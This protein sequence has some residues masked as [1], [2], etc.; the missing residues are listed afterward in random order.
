MKVKHTKNGNVKLVMGLEQAQALRAYL[1][2]A[3]RL[4]HEVPLDPHS[5]ELIHNIDDEMS[6][7]DIDPYL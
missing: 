7:A 2:F 1:M 5:M 6:A 4:S 3:Y